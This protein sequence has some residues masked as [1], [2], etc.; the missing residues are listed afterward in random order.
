MQEPIEEQPS[1]EFQK[2]RVYVQKDPRTESFRDRTPTAEYS[3]YNDDGT[4]D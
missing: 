4:Q 2:T 1:E 3:L